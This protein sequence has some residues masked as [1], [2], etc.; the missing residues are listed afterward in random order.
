MVEC[1][2][3]VSKRFWISYVFRVVSQGSLSFSVLTH[4]PCPVSCLLILHGTLY[5]T[6]C[7]S[8]TQSLLLPAGVLTSKLHITTTA[9]RKLQSGGKTASDDVILFLQTVSMIIPTTMVNWSLCSENIGLKPR[10]SDL[11]PASRLT[12]DGILSSLF[13]PIYVL[14]LI[15]SQFLLFSYCFWWCYGF[16]KWCLF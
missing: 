1:E 12:P 6:P 15:S 9:M 11:P 16:S 2:P 4:V 5:K 13:H 3:A 14:R 7:N 10:Q 8:L